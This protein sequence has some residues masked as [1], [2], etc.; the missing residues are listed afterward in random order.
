MSKND[1]KINLEFVIKLLKDFRTKSYIE[2]EK[3]IKQLEK[4][5]IKY[6]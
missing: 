2:Q 1:K 5:L 4:E 3:I 6:E